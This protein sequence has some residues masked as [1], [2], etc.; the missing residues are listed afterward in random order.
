MA[1][2][3]ASLIRVTIA[4]AAKKARPAEASRAL[5]AYAVGYSVGHALDDE[6]ARGR[7]LFAQRIDLL[8]GGRFVP[9]LRL[10]HA[11]EG[12]D[13]EARRRG[14]VDVGDLVGAG[15]E[16]AAAVLHRRAGLGDD[17]LEDVGV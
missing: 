15:D 10:R 2:D 16:V 12:D 9:G 3:I 4:P 5:V 13:D 17:V 7:R 11:V 6:R 8:L 1:P 14:T